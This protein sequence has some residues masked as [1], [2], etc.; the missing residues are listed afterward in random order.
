MV[1]KDSELSYGDM[2]LFPL[3]LRSSPHPSPPCSLSQEADLYQRLYWWFPSPLSLVSFF[4]MEAQARDGKERGE[5][6]QARD[7]LSHVP[8]FG[9]ILD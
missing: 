9:A 5:W 3:P 8:L 1:I 4:L 2:E 7:L 6:S